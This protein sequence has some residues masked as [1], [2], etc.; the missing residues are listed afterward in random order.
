M[1]VVQQMWRMLQTFGLS[2]NARIAEPDQGM[3]ILSL[4]DYKVTSY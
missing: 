4:G 2:D 3:N 1:A